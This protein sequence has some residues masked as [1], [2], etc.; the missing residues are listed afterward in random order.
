MEFH[1]QPFHKNVPS[2]VL[3]DDLR[4]TARRLGKTIISADLYTRH[5][6][7]NATTL[8]RRFGKWNEV[9]RIA[10]L[11][12]AKHH[13]IPTARLFDNL[14]NVWEQLGR[15]PVRD[16]MAPPL[17]QYSAAAY[18]A[19]F[20]TWRQALMQFVAA[21]GG[22]VG[23]M[24]VASGKA[25][26]PRKRSAG[27]NINMRLRFD[28][29]RRDNFKCCACGRSP[30]THPDTILHV[31]HIIPWHSGGQTL[32]DNL[33]TLCSQCNIGKSDT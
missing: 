20:G 11:S 30:A 13:N 33:Q 31:D 10:G 23:G 28:V 7:Y 29:M 15:Q 2:D 25:S 24:E 18:A 1:L 16:D 17:S 27:R 26:R 9:L 19:R 12:I 32:F 22:N 4:A 3:I 8:A 14:R 6:T 5:G 21:M